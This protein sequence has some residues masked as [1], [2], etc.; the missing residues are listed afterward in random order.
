MKCPECQNQDIIS[1][2]DGIMS[3]KV[4]NLIFDSGPQWMKYKPSE[5]KKKISETRTVMKNS[6]TIIEWQN[7]VRTNI[8]VGKNILLASEE[9]NRI[10]E[11][12]K[13]NHNIIES[14]LEI[15]SSSSKK[16]I[17]RGR[18]TQRVAAASVFTACRLA[19][20]PITL[21]EIANKC[22]LNRNELSKL[23]RLIKRKLK[24]KISVSNSINFLPKFIQI[25]A[26]PKNVENEARE[27][28][29]FV[30]ESQYRHGISP[31]AL[32]GA[33]IYLSCKKA[34]VKRSQLEIAKTLGTSEVTLRNRSKEI[35]ALI[36]SK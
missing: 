16:G 30:E 26:L 20:L 36:E 14:S 25:L 22:S 33:A 6:A 24:L 21:D 5:G 15:F 19:N 7:S 32:L 8:T 28:I 10:T 23:H 9:I 2:G 4:C 1:E 11:L 27:I 12:L 34:K 31:I 3:C 35:K 18:S 13:L 29:T 17:V